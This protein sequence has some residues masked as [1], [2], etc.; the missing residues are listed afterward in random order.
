[1]IAV[2]F[3]IALIPLMS[4]PFHEAIASLRWMLVVVAIG[5]VAAA[6]VTISSRGR[7]LGQGMLIGE[8]AMLPLAFAGVLAANLGIIGWW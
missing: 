1:V 3:V 2:A 7:A 6:A 8:T 5:Y 4:D